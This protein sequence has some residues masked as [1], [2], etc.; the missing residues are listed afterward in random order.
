MRKFV[1]LIF[2]L[3]LFISFVFHI[4]DLSAATTGPSTGSFRC[5]NQNDVKDCYFSVPSPSSDYQAYRVAVQ[6]FVDEIFRD[7]NSSIAVEVCIAQSNSW[8]GSNPLGCW[9]PI[10]ESWAQPPPIRVFPS[11]GPD[12][13]IVPMGNPSNPGNWANIH[14]RIKNAYSNTNVSVW[15]RRVSIDDFQASPSTIDT[16]QSSTLNWTVGAAE[17][18]TVDGVTYTYGV[19]GVSTGSKVVIPGSTTTYTVSATGPGGFNGEFTDVRQTTV[20]VNPPPTHLECISNTCTEVSEAGNNL[21]GCTT[22]GVSCGSSCTPDSSCAANTCTGSTCTDSCGNTY[23]GTLNCGVGTG[24]VRVIANTSDAYY[25]IFPDGTR[26]GWN[27]SHDFTGVP[28]GP[29][30]VDA[31]GAGGSVSPSGSQT[32]NLGQTITFTVTFGGPLPIIPIPF[33]GVG[34]CGD[35][36]CD[37]GETCSTCGYDCGV[38]PA[39]SATVTLKRWDGSSWVHSPV[40]VSAGTS[41]PLELIG[42]NVPN[43][44]C[45]ASWR[46]AVPYVYYSSVVPTVTTTYTATCRGE[47][48][49]DARDSLIVNVNQASFVDI[50]V[51]T[52]GTNYS[53]GPITVLPG[54]RVWLQWEAPYDPDDPNGADSCILNWLGRATYVGVRTAQPQNTTTYRATCTAF[55]TSASDEVTVNVI[56][57]LSVTLTANPSSGISPLTSILTAN[58]SGSEGSINYYFWYDCT[59]PTTNVA[60]CPALPSPA[61]G[62]CAGNGQGYKCNSVTETSIGITKTYFSGGGPYIA[63]VIVERGPLS[64]EDRT[65]VTVTAP[66]PP[67]ASNISVT[68]PNYCVSGPAATIGWTYSDSSGSPQSAYQVQMDEQGSFRVPE[69]DSGKVISGSNSYFTGQ[70]ILQFNKTYKTRVRV[71]NSFDIVSDWK[72]ASGN[73]NTPPY[74]Y[75]QVDFSWTANGILNNPSPP[76]NKPVQFTDATVFNGNPNGREWSWTFG[77]GGSSTTQNPAHTYAAEGSYYVT[78]TA[79]DNANQSCARTKGPLIIQKPIPRW[80]E[81]APR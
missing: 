44:T 59:D 64:A 80:R 55:G 52:D 81:I 33:P 26:N 76:L 60:M 45:V 78:L 8:P 66:P 34:I 46:G 65:T 18:V 16:G 43:N 27:G 74:A 68:E 1:F 72:V 7:A 36:R 47:D 17:T 69:V 67:T 29:Y 73:F 48:G 5:D 79:T 71:W 4:N 39:S 49:V 13:Q 58:V 9:T 56:S 63:K 14:I 57:P 30:S 50:D 11:S 2:G 77:D 42:Y 22:A 20:T 25:L 12:D 41:V 62:G 24:T 3:L 21:G 32:L 40:T 19:S 35:T 54:T 10:P 37:G 38:C 6:S 28:T 53:D 70:G 51:S 15:G 23:S 61:P 31:S 75:P